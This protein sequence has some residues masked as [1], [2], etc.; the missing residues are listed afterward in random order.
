[1]LRGKVQKNLGKNSAKKFSRTAKFLNHGIWRTKISKPARPFVPKLCKPGVFFERK[2]CRLTTF[3]SFVLN[4]GVRV[5]DCAHFPSRMQRSQTVQVRLYAFL[6]QTLLTSICCTDSPNKRWH[7]MNAKKTW[8]Q[9]RPPALLSQLTH[10][11]VWAHMDRHE[12][13]SRN[14]RIKV[15]EQGWQKTWQPETWQD[16]ALFS[17]PWK[18]GH[19]SPHFG[20]ISCLNC[21]ENLERKENIH[22]RKLKNSS[23]DG[24]L[25]LQISVSCRG[26]TRPDIL[27]LL[28]LTKADCW[29]HSSGIATRT[30][31]ITIGCKMITYL[32]QKH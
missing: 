16:S 26:Q 27:R 13:F 20:A 29:T 32:I 2:R 28:L 6:C 31:Q 17:L 4:L 9:I 5:P 23:G 8:T 21:T 15:P 12:P 7:C 18:S 24:A 25:E 19:F 10:R 11:H 3:F 30:P 22:R 14:P 1:M